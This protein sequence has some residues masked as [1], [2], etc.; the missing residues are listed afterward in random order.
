MSAATQTFALQGVRCAGCVLK[1]ERSLQA[2]PGVQFARGNATQKRLRLIW[3]E[4]EHSLDGLTKSIQDLG[5]EASVLS[6]DTKGHQEPSLLPR[7]AAAAIGMMNIMAFS[8]SVWSG[9]VTDMAAGTMQ[10]MHWLSAAVALPVVLYS[11]SAF[12]TPALRAMRV[13]RMTMDT[14]ITLAI[15][16]TFAA[17][18]F[19]TW[20][21]SDH[22]YY[23]AV[24]SL[25]FFLLIGR[26][27]EQSLRRRSGD[28]AGNL[29]TLMEITAHRMEPD[30]TTV[31]IPADALRSGDRVLV[32]S[33]ERVPA[34]GVLLSQ[35][36][37]LDESILTGETL[38]RCAIKGSE[39]AAGA[40]LQT[41]PAEIQVTRVGDAAYIG[42]MAQLVD[43]VVAHKGAMQKLSDRFAAGYIPLVL[44]GGGIGFLLWYF[45]L[46]ASFADALMIAVAVLVVTCPCA[47]GLATPAVTTRAVNLLMRAGVV[48][49]SGDALE[50]LGAVEHIYLDKTGTA[51]NPTLTV[52]TGLD[53]SVLNNARSLAASSQHPLARA[54]MGEHSVAAVTGAVE[55]QGQ[56]V[57]AP[58]GARLGS[59]EFTGAQTKEQ[60]KPSL[61]YR[62]PSGEIE[63]ITF[64]EAP[65][66]D[67]GVFLAQTSK[68]S[69]PVT[70]LSGDTKLAVKR[71]AQEQ[72]FSDWLGEQ[73]PKDKLQVVQTLQSGNTTALMVGDGINDS[74]ALGGASVSASFSGAT[75]IAQVAA[76]I[77]LLQPRLCLIT[78]AIVLARQ[79][80]QLIKQNLWFATVYN[81]ITVP[82][83]LCGMLNPLIAA[84]LMSS[85][86]LI[87]LTNGLRL[88]G[89]K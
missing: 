50:T 32:A 72:G 27:L 73:K 47:A 40:V 34:D 37:E 28:A 67:L 14:P 33:G 5:Y 13:G 51:S 66:A 45:A 42:Q 69:L 16:I 75:Q 7:L 30:N 81:V 38:P 61:W 9:L 15:W 35:Q 3:D 62:A 49:K 60:E 25:I 46:G 64:D 10:F 39:I 22:V 70:L 85:S 63:Q 12:H 79:A 23:D 48:V 1:I 68:L 53:V 59:A 56:G 78:D 43:D 58:S 71:F 54:L 76:D 87:V 83:A 26:V 11:G 52:T 4:D 17:S 41:G 31:D 2:L 21:G 84:L 18:L 74:A 65:R 82:L 36:V 86:S 24:V 89:Q 55:V 6:G 44:G 29:R 57:E 19:E 8:I 88:K 80:S 20:R 77:L